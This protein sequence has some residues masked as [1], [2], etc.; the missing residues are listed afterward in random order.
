MCEKHE[1]LVRPLTSNIFAINKRKHWGIYIFS[2]GRWKTIY[3][4]LKYPVD[5]YVLFWSC[6]SWTG[7]THKQK[8]LWKLSG[9]LVI[10]KKQE[11][12][13]KTGHSKC[14]HRPQASSETIHDDSRN[15]KFYSPVPY[16]RLRTIFSE[17]QA[18][19][20][21]LS[22]KIG[23]RVWA[24][25]AFRSVKA[26]AP[27]SLCSGYCKAIWALCFN[28][29]LKFDTWNS[30]SFTTCHTHRDPSRCE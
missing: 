24:R 17:K 30:K 5:V 21:D 22:L 3:I 9:H 27:S 15:L 14:S 25:S 19:T 6:F 23:F 2:L 26:T 10:G 16:S 12:L 4:L 11:S 28:F 7:E 13:W 8:L 29:V 1:G 20:D 18:C